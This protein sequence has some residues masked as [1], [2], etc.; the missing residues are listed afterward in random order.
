MPKPIIAEGSYPK[1]D[2]LT[3]DPKTARILSPAYAT[4][5]GELNAILQYVY[6]SINFTCAGDEATAEKLKGIAIAEMMHLDM[7]AEAL[8]RLGSQ[9]VYT[10]NPPA[11]FNFYSTK[12][13]SYSRSLRNMIED[14]IMGEKYAV[15]TYERMLTRLKNPTLQTLIC[16]IIDDENLHI[17]VLKEILEG[18]KK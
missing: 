4:S 5:C 11:Q 1:L 8:I 6:H 13:V 15:Y 16:R 14:D 12:F 9:P 7:L 10:F 18:M 17:E 2:G 3:C